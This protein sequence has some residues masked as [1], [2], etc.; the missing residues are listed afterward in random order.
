MNILIVN[1]GIIPVTFYGGTERVIWYLGKELVK[2][3]HEVTYLVRK[4]SFCDFAS[5]IYLDNKKAIAEQIPDNT[6]IVHFNFLPAD[7]ERVSTPVF[8]FL[9]RSL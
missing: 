1:T 2:M 9:I 3:G 8:I 4:G 5:V 7:I 6:D